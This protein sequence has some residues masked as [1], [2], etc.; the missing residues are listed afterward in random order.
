LQRLRRRNF[1]EGNEKFPQKSFKK[2]G[3]VNGTRID[4]GNILKDIEPVPVGNTF[5]GLFFF[6]Y[7]HLNKR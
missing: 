6:I 3:M 1:L 4:L 2:K 7:Y 5:G